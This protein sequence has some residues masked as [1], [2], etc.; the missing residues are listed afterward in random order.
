MNS[1]DQ[2]FERFPALVKG[3]ATEKWRGSFNARTLAR[4]SSY[5]NGTSIRSLRIKEQ[6]KG[7]GV[8]SADVRGSLTVPYVVK[9]FFLTAKGVMRLAPQGCSCP[10]EY[11]CKHAAAVLQF[12]AK[13]AERFSAVSN[14]ISSEPILDWKTEDWLRRMRL[15]A[16]TNGM[17]AEAKPYSKF[18]VYRLSPRLNH[19]EPVLNL[20]LGNRLKSGGVSLDQ[21]NPTADTS[22]PPRY[23]T[24]EDIL[25]VIRMRVLQRLQYGY[26]GLRLDIPGSAELLE[27]IFATGRLFVDDLQNHKGVIPVTMGSPETVRAGWEHLSSGKTKPALEFSREGLVFTATETPLYIDFEK[28]E[29][30]KLEADLSGKMLRLWARAGDE[31]GHS[32]E[33]GGKTPLISWK[34]HACAG[35]S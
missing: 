28:A 25:L 12:L 29:I 17:D 2:F 30:G 20:R 10:V 34:T 23:M 7:F 27:D 9:I 8:I 14:V 4:A 32:S 1:L 15:L 19:S 11:D 5:A 24:P 26:E 6:G 21:S 13:N 31:T 16:D 18:L 3:L 22:N 33:R 35:G